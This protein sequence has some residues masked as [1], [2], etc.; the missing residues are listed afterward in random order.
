MGMDGENRRLFPF[1]LM[2]MV[3]VLVGV[4][5]AGMVGIGRVRAG[6]VVGVTF[7]MLASVVSAAASYTSTC[8]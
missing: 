2:C 8:Y 1:S 7:V 3:M 5:V 6:G 4:C